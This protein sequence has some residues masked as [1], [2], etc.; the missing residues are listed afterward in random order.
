MS[1]HMSIHRV[2]SIDTYVTGWVRQKENPTDFKIVK[3]PLLLQKQ[4][5]HQQKAQ[6]L[7]FNF[8]TLKV[9]VALSG[10]RDNNLQ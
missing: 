9:G 8:D 5:L 10:G 6:D 4:K 2:I 3:E 7:S 1:Y